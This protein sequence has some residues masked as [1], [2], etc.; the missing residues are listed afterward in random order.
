MWPFACRFDGAYS[1]LYKAPGGKLK[2]YPAIQKWARKIATI[3]GMADTIDVAD[4]VGSYYRQLFM[5]NPSGIVP[6]IEE[7]VSE[8]FDIDTTDNS[9]ETI[10]LSDSGIFHRRLL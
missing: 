7:T 5:L 4:A 10:M 3:E 6:T 2:N 9:I 1:I 8:L